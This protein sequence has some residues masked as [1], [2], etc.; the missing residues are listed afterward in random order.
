MHAIEDQFFSPNYLEIRICIFISASTL[1]D[2][3][4]ENESMYTVRICYLSFQLEVKYYQC[5][6]I[7]LVN[8]F[9]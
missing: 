7:A 2:F 4:S 5:T 3:T 9:I 8:A 6:D 1:T